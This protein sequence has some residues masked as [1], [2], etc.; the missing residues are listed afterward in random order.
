M[1]APAACK[2]TT[3]G[4]QCFGGNGYMKDY[5]QDKRFLDAKHVQALLGFAPMRKL[6][7]IKDMLT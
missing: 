3:D 7:M 6:S 1:I 2:L 4:I 5:V